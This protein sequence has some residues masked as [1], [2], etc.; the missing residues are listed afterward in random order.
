MSTK[1]KQYKFTCIYNSPDKPAPKIALEDEIN[2]S[3]YDLLKSLNDTKSKDKDRPVLCMLYTRVI[4]NEPCVIACN[5]KRVMFVKLSQEPFCDLIFKIPMDKFWE[6]SF[7]KDSVFL[8]DQTRSMEFLGY[9]QYPKLDNLRLDLESTVSLFE[10]EKYRPSSISIPNPSINI[11]QLCALA[12]G[13]YV[14]P[15]YLKPIDRLI[16]RYK[17]Q[18]I[19]GANGKNPNQIQIECKSFVFISVKM[20]IDSYNEVLPNSEK[21]RNIFFRKPIE[22]KSLFPDWGLNDASSK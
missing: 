7:N 12:F 8:I 10:T 14:N 5:G 2:K 16:D 19:V 9:T 22:Q 4:N 20:L 17:D 13:V 11:A 6:I 18:V 15:D 1:N 21:A 3:A